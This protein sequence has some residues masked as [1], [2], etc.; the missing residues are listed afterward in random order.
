MSETV[1]GTHPLT[2]HI[3]EMLVF[4]IIKALYYPDGRETHALIGTGFFIGSRRFLS[5]R[6][7]FEGKGSALDM[8]DATGIAVYCAHTV[9]L[10]RKV[11]L[12][13][14]DVQ[15][16]QTHSK[17]RDANTARGGTRAKM[18]VRANVLEARVS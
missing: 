18:I 7:V 4:P 17:R 16:I 11:V 5:A 9:N 1:T 12:R 15:S 2:R 10:N 14:I 6:H 3:G 8:E 13:H